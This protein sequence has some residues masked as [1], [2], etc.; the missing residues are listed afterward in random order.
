MTA[1]NVEVRRLAHA[2]VNPFLRVL[3][4]RPDGYHEIET[5]VHPID[6]ADDLVI[7]GGA[8]EGP[9]VRV[10]G[11]F[12]A[13]VPP[14]PDNLVMRAIGAMREA[15]EPVSPEVTLTKRIPVAAGLGGGSA[16]AAATL[17]GLAELCGAAST[18]DELLEI[19]SSL[20]SD[21]PALLFEA[22]ILARGRGEIVSEIEIQ[23]CR[24]RVI[25][26]AFGIAAADAYRWW[27]E[28]GGITGPDPGPLLDALVVGDLQAAGRLL[29]NDLEGP[30]LRRHPEVEE[31]KSRL[32]AEGALGAVVSGSGPSVAGL[33][34]PV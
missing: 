25:P 10:D 21:V 16:D 7:T 34:P 27:D 8:R 6:L 5:L 3:G 11:P 14:G 9:T 4:S 31:A 32:L 22:P 23:P 18:M 33:Y 20:G 28:D 13:G 2:K 29:F 24:W 17:L 15:C 30:I 19:A 12:A 26:A 1:A